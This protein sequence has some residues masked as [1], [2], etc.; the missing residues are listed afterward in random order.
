MSITAL[1]RTA[2]ESFQKQWQNS[3]Q[4]AP[5]N[6]LSSFED[7]SAALSSSFLNQS[8]DSSLV[9]P[10]IL[11]NYE[12]KQKAAEQEAQGDSPASSSTTKTK[13]TYDNPLSKLHQASPVKHIQILEELKPQK[14]DLLA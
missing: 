9:T 6:L 1:T 14:M 7:N 10:Q 3:Q 11:K 4:N 8:L 2:V 5:K 12:A 13:Y